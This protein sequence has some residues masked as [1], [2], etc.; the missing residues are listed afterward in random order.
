MRI[1]SSWKFI[2]TKAFADSE[3]GEQMQ[4]SSDLII[5]V[6]GGTGTVIFAVLLSL[7][8][9]RFRRK[10]QELLERLE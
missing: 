5:I 7:L 4:I 2:I 6:I 8:P 1:C 3:K 9:G 10:R